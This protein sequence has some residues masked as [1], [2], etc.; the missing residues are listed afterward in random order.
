AWNPQA[1]TGREQ[2]TDGRL[3][4]LRKLTGLQTCLRCTQ[5]ENI[6]RL[7]IKVTLDNVIVLIPYDLNFDMSYFSAMA[8][9]SFSG[10]DLMYLFQPGHQPACH[11]HIRPSRDAGLSSYFLRKRQVPHLCCS[12]CILLVFS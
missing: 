6:T 10:R 12:I 11:R 5:M 3:T 1:P 7:F 4:G 8:L 2:D 9:R